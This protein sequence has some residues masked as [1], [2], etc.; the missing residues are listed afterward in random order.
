MWAHASPG[1]ASSFPWG[2]LRTEYARVSVEGKMSRVDRWPERQ[3]PAA[4]SSAHSGS[5]SKIQ[6]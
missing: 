1:M 2:N 6:R 4:L 3:S 5:F